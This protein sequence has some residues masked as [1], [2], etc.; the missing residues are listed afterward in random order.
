VVEAAGSQVGMAGP[1]LTG[2][3]AT[4]ARA[5][6]LLGV[7]EVAGQAAQ[8]AGRLEGLV[9]EVAVVGECKRGKSSLINALLDTDVLPVGVLPLTAVPTVLER[10]DSACLVVFTDGR[11]EEHPLSHVGRFVTEEINCRP[12]QA[13]EGVHQARGEEVEPPRRRA[14]TLTCSSGSR[15][16]SHSVAR[17]K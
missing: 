8:V 1:T 6:R 11:H 5:A 15:A 10:G 4:L 16:C 12:E 17:S 14:A 2:A 9:L 13:P 7:A 3:L